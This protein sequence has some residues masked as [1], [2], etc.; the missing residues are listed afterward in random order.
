MSNIKFF[1]DISKSNVR[2][3][4]GKGASLGEMLK[5][6]IPVPP[7][8]VITIEAYD[9]SITPEL[10]REILKAFEGL[11][12]KRVAVRSSAIV[13]D[14]KTSSWAGQL[15]SYLNVEP[16]DLIN[17]IKE[18]WKSIASERAR[19]YASDK[20]LSKEQLT[21]AV[22]I[23]KM[24]DSQVSGVTFTA[25]P[26]MNNLNEI[27]IES[28]FGLGELLVGGI[29]TPDNFIVDKKTLKIK[30]KTI[31]KKPSVSDKQIRELANLCIKIEELFKTPQDIEWAIDEKK[32]IWILQSRPIT[33][34]VN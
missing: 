2:E 28:G 33:T 12:T 27:I 22:V 31:Q 5:K 30:N 25:N 6:G 9:K 16:K 32:N 19:A 14:S 3:V 1:K 29:I 24:V 15:E 4:G 34:L 7:G 8:F 11:K 17:K 20:N 23:Q 26:I 18:C 10:E 21:T 13:E